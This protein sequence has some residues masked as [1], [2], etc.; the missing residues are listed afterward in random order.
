MNPTKVQRSTTN[1]LTDLPNVGPAVARALETIGVNAPSD[2]E[3]RD[4]FQM[5]ELFCERTNVRE[6]P[7]LLDTFM[8]ITDYVSGNEPRPWWAYTEERKRRYGRVLALGRKAR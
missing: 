7:C 1:K 2:L 3:S 4:P 8:S 6:D 5:Y